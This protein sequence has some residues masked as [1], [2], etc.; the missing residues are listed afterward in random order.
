MPV[1]LSITGVA[2]CGVRA[3]IIAFLFRLFQGVGGGLF[4]T[5]IF[6][7]AAS[8]AKDGVV[9]APTHE[10]DARPVLAA[11]SPWQSTGS[12]HRRGGCNPSARWIF[13]QPTSLHQLPEV[14]SLVENIAS[15][16]GSS[17]CVAGRGPRSAI[18]CRHV[19]GPE[20]SKT[21]A[22]NKAETTG[23][24]MNRRAPMVF[25]CSFDDRNADYEQYTGIDQKRRPR[26][27]Q[28]PF[29]G[30]REV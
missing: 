24:E 7:V 25:P 28:A 29:K 1:A 23:L 16:Q 9:A 4:A 17:P 21:V 10:K 30:K 13:A 8:I 19:R 22:P 26:P 14:F 18:R 20:A 15:R 3:S 27:R 12:R 5:T 2:F 11:Y 6:P